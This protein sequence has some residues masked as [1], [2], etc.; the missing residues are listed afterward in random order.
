MQVTS[1][2][3]VIYTNN[4]TTV[5]Q[6]TQ[7]KS[8]TF[9]ELING[10]ETLVQQSI[11]DIELEK[12]DNNNQRNSFGEITIPLDFDMTNIN[13]IY[14]NME[15][16]AANYNHFEEVYAKHN[17]GGAGFRRQQE[18]L[19]WEERFV[20]THLQYGQ[21]FLFDVDVDR[22]LGVDNVNVDSI[23][24]EFSPYLVEW[25][26]HLKNATNGNKYD[27]AP[28]FEAFINKWTA[29]GESDEEDIRIRAQVYVGMGLLDYG[30]QK[31]MYINDLPIEDKKEHGMWLVDNPPL[32][33]ALLKTLDSLKAEDLFTIKLDDIFEQ[34]GIKLEELEKKKKEVEGSDYK[35]PEFIFTG[36]VNLKND[37]SAE[38]QKYNQFI[39]DT[40]IDSFKD[41]IDSMEISEENSRQ[42]YKNNPRVETLDL[43]NRKD[44]VNLLIDNLKSLV[45]KH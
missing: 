22:N 2:T 17:I 43:T 13:E 18:Q 16:N 6:N 14:K 3:Q 11:P 41:F 23:N 39:F 19:P 40:I 35:E 42:K 8:N 33:E 21:G 38:A 37:N 27:D 24:Q 29:N 44:A 15:H 5:K 10:T 30:K 1:T 34:F 31:A 28:E 45:N 32:K 20:H 25:N 12:T 4:E 36:D 9:L 7:E 26:H